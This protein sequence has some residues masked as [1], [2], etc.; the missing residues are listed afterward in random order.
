MSNHQVVI[1][2]ETTGWHVTCLT[3][4]L[5]KQGQRVAV[6][7]WLHL[8]TSIGPL[9]SSSE[10]FG[11][12]VIND[13]ELIIVRSMP[14]GMDPAYRLEEVIFRMN[15]LSRFVD[16]GKIVINTPQSL[17]ISIDKHLSLCH[18]KKH[19]LRVPMTRV[20][21]GIDAVQHAWEQFDGDC[22]IKPLFG[23][24]G[25]GLKRL[26]SVHD[27]QELCRNAVAH[28]PKAGIFLMQEYISHEGWDVRIMLAGPHTFAMRRRAA[29][30]E[31]RTNLACGG[32]A[33]AFSPPQEWIDYARKAAD[34]VGSEIAGVDLLPSKD[35]GV[36][37]LEV[38]GV[39]GWR[40][41]ERATGAPITEAVA[42]HLSHTVSET[43]SHEK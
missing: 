22:L 42:R 16:H 17:E 41:L 36:V 1:L 43:F 8:S 39:P 35:G 3:R 20:V 12:P 2:G 25:R 19:G 37:V 33:E 5:K 7:S 6:V 24:Q 28:D 40:G 14:A 21:Q 31:W 15:L 9:C 38:N 34:A 32:S 18:L 27:V 4:A 30:G 23:S 29:P 26:T 10:D 13:A 11:P